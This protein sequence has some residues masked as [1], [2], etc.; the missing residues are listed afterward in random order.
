[1]SA[2]PGPLTITM[3]APAIMAARAGVAN[4]AW[5]NAVSTLETLYNQGKTD[6]ADAYLNTIKDHM[7]Q[8][9]YVQAMNIW[10]KH[11]N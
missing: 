11:H 4:T 8:E 10:V 7:N 3:S 1:M 6:K 9:Q 5:K 2:A